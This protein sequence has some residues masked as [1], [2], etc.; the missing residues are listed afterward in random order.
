VSYASL[1]K[2]LVI[3]FLQQQIITKNILIFIQ[4]IKISLWLNNK[5]IKSGLLAYLNFVSKQLETGYYQRP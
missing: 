2:V 1:N 3:S 4:T 5:R